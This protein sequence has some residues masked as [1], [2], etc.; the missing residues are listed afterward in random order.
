M[1]L[2]RLHFGQIEG[3]QPLGRNGFELVVADFEVHGLGFDEHLFGRRRVVKLWPC[4]RRAL[5]GG[6]HHGPFDQTVMQRSRQPLEVAPFGQTVESVGDVRRNACVAVVGKQRQKTVGRCLPWVVG[7]PRFETHRYDPFGGGLE[8]RGREHQFI[9]RS[10]F[11]DGVGKHIVNPRCNGLG[12]RVSFDQIPAHRS[13]L[14]HL[15]A[16]VGHELATD[17]V[18]TN[19]AHSFPLPRRH[20]H[21]S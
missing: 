8:K 15:N 20:F 1:G 6:R 12:G 3:E 19:I 10:V 7:D 4:S 11:D 9:G 14:L 2:N 17:D 18:A 21:A 5:L 16:V 13:D